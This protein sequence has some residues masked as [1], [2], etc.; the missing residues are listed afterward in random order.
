MYFPN[1]ESAKSFLNSDIKINPKTKRKI[2][3]TG[4]IYENIMK[5]IILNY[6]Q[7]LDINSDPIIVEK[8]CI[9][10]PISTFHTELL[11]S[12]YILYNMYIT[13]DYMYKGPLNKKDKRL[14]KFK[15]NIYNR[16][17]INKVDSVIM[18]D[19]DNCWIRYKNI[20]TDDN[21]IGNSENI[22]NN[23]YSIIYDIILLN[24]IGSAVTLD[25]VILSKSSDTIK[26]HII[27]ID[28]T[29]NIV[30]NINDIFKTD[31]I[32]SFIK[33]NIDDIK[34]K[35]KNILPYIN[36]YS[37]KYNININ[38]NLLDSL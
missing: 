4:N 17:I 25:D 19:K 15:N 23:L 24:I 22:S 11:D 28:K 13:Q 6:P 12:H 38:M 21:I 14:L 27:N 29:H 18:K 33:N 1:I 8:N 20:L 7:L 9:A 26:Y 37:I 31:N 32:K 16:Y 10:K 34:Y 30:Y 5:E 36:N 2:S 3:N 35:I